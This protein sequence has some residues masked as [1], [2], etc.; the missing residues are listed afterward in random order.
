MRDEEASK[1]HQPRTNSKAERDKE[2][3]A[4]LR[5]RTKGKEPSDAG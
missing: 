1:A 4:E 3:A 5:T 2:R